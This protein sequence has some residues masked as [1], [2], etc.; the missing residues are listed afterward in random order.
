MTFTRKQKQEALSK[1]SRE[2]SDFIMSNEVSDLIEAA[3]REAGLSETQSDSADTEI[4][5]AML[6]LQT[7]DEAITNIAKL[8]SKVPENF[9]KLKIDLK[10]NIFDKIDT[11]K[12]IGTQTVKRDVEEKRIIEKKKISN[13]DVKQKLKEIVQIYSLTDEQSSILE[14]RIVEK[15]INNLKEDLDISDVFASQ[16]QNEVENRIMK[17]STVVDKPEVKNTQPTLPEKN[18]M[19]VIKAPSYVPENL[20]G[21]EITDVEEKPIIGDQFVPKA[22][23]SKPAIDTVQ[24]NISGQEKITQIKNEKE[25]EKSAPT[26]KPKSQYT[27]DPYREP[28]E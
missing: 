2:V 17:K 24:Q 8:S 3:L 21:E 22:E 23:N 1:L 4:L 12:E 20:P 18:E 13:I 11:Y 28:I 14:T 7:L 19:A 16:L 15:H 25:P 5:C 27:V 6:E 26:E 9:F 10:N